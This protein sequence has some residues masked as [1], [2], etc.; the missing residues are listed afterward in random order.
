MEIKPDD[1]LA[2]KL[3]PIPGR[4]QRQ[5]PLQY[6]SAFAYVYRIANG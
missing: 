4:E 3:K 6:E 5:R 1:L 2:V